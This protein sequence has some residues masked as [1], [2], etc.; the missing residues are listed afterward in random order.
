MFT[1][2]RPRAFQVL[3]CCT[4]SLLQGYRLAQDLALWPLRNSAISAFE[5]VLK[6]RDRRV[7]AEKTL[8][9]PA[10]LR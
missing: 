4:A 3:L 10:R 9:T 6:R 7:T 1:G 5:S 8:L 2:R